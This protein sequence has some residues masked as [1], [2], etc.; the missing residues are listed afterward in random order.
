MTKERGHNIPLE[1]GDENELWELFHENSKVTAYDVSLS[2]EEV[3]A[4]M[5]KLSGSLDYKGY[6][7]IDLPRS[8]TPIK[9]SFEELITRRVTTRKLVP[10]WLTLE[11][12]NTI[13]YYAYGITRDNSN[14]N[15]PRPFR[16][17]PSAGALYPLEIF[18]YS[19]HIDG[20][21]PGLYHYNPTEKNLR[22]LRSGDLSTEISKSLVQKELAVENSMLIFVTAMFKRSTF[23]YGNRGYRF[24]L[25]EAGHVAQNINLVTTGLGLGSVNICGYFDRQ[26]DDLLDLDGVTH[27]T[28]YIIAIGKKLE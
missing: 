27:S 10:C 28:I 23:K 18:F 26:V 11:N 6:P 21:L 8:L 20:E 3:L 19:S 14:S 17:V 12:I 24:A 25:L 1:S 22:L 7:T 2:D 4:A 16:I 13:L 15:F 9:L 5:R